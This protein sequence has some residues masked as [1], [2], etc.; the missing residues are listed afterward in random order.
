M[1]RA[2]SVKLA[3]KLKAR[4]IT[5]CRGNIFSDV[6]PALDNNL[7]AYTEAAA[8]AGIISRLSTQ[9][10]PNDHVTR[11]ELV[12]M[13]LSAMEITPSKVPSGFSDVSSVSD[14]SKYINA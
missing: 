7:C 1:T 9:F 12:K 4:G 3:V 8:N 14:F 2:E 11:A 10:R 5:E 6:N 13:L